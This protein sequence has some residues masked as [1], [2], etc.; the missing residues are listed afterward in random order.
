MSLHPYRTQTNFCHTRKTWGCLVGFSCLWVWKVHCTKWYL[1]QPTKKLFTRLSEWL[2]IEFL[3]ARG[4]AVCTKTLPL[5]H[6]AGDE[7]SYRKK[8]VKSILCRIL[9]RLRRFSQYLV[10]H[11][12]D[13]VALFGWALSWHQKKLRGVQVAAL[14]RG[15]CPQSPKFKASNLSCCHLLL[16]RPVKSHTSTEADTIA[17]ILC[18]AFSQSR[19]ELKMGLLS[20]AIPQLRP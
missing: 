17:S 7:R 12:S 13:I 2:N 10:S 3:E 15:T 14:G 16:L 5:Y 6:S 4:K 18:E 11:R 9:T 20:F 19:K 8:Y 1:L